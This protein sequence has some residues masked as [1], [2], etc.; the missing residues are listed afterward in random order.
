[1]W[2]T[3]PSDPAV[4][5]AALAATAAQPGRVAYRSGGAS[6]LLTPGHGWTLSVYTG[7]APRYR[8]DFL[9]V[10]RH[11]GTLSVDLVTDPRAAGHVAT[12]ERTAMPEVHLAGQAAL[13]YLARVELVVTPFDALAGRSEVARAVVAAPGSSR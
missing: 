5:L 3:R 10:R 6:L 9:I 4:D 11:D 7:T 2:A 8:A 1:M 13:D 12:E